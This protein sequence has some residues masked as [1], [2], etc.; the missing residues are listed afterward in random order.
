V[1]PLKL[2]YPIKLQK[3]YKN[4]TQTI[5]KQYTKNTQTIQKQYT[6]NKKQ[7]KTTIYTK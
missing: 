7:Y 5:Q 6:N 3:Q 1:S 4:N 2:K